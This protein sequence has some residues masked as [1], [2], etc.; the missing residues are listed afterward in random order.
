MNWLAMLAASYTWSKNLCHRAIRS[1]GRRPW[2]WKSCTADAQLR[3][4]IFDA[5]VTLSNVY[6]KRM[7]Y[8]TSRLYLFSTS[9]NRSCGRAITSKSLIPFIVSAAT[10]ALMTA[11]SVA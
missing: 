4:R 1:A 8:F 10:M 2:R 5:G 7:N 11:S 9:R 6:A 3:N